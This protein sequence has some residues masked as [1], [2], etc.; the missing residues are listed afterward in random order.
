MDGY[1]EGADV[2]A[3]R[4][5]NLGEQAQQGDLQP[6]GHQLVA[7]PAAGYLQGH[8]QRAVVPAARA[9]QQ[10]GLMN[11]ARAIADALLAAQARLL[12]DARWI[13]VQERLSSRVRH[14]LV[15]RR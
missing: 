5:V 11:R 10:L 6:E 15:R 1:D 9:G 3:Q 4:L 8:P 12:A 7:V 13:R 14:V 2:A